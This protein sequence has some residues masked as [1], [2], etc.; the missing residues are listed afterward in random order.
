MK[1]RKLS[2]TLEGGWAVSIISCH[3]VLDPPSKGQGLLGWFSDSGVRSSIKLSYE[4]FVVN[5]MI[6][7]ICCF[8]QGRLLFIILDLEG[9][10]NI[11]VFR[12]W[13]LTF[14]L[15]AAPPGFQVNTKYLRCCSGKW[16][17]NDGLILV[18]WLIEPNI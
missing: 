10:E 1:R 13:I 4:L 17:K 3:R 2:A 15:T 14:K 12:F 7:D 11:Q 5:I 8:R 18:A 6:Y 16:K 9:V